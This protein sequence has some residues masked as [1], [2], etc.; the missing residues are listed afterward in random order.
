MHGAVDDL[1][2]QKADTMKGIQGL[3]VAVGLGVVA[4]P[5]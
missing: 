4:A 3:I 2:L 1:Y 5:F